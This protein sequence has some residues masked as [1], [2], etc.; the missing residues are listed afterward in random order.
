MPIADIHLCAPVYSPDADDLEAALDVNTPF[1]EG[2]FEETLRIGLTLDVHERVGMLDVIKPQRGEG[3][4]CSPKGETL[5]RTPVGEEPL[6]HAAVGQQ[7]EGARVDAERFGVGGPHECF[8]D[9]AR[10]MPMFGQEECC[11]Q[12]GG[13]G[14]NDENVCRGGIHALL[15]ALANNKSRDPASYSGAMPAAIDQ[16]RILDSVLTVWREHGYQGSS[17]RRIAALA[18]I[19]EMTLFRRYGD[20]AA[21]FRAALEFEAGQFR[22]DAIHYTGSLEI[23]LERIVG[24]YESL[25]ERS[26]PIILD[27]LLEAP[28]NPELAQIRPVPLEAIAH[29][30]AVME[31]YQQEGRLRQ[32]PPVNAVLVLLSPLLTA[33]LLRQAQP[34]LGLTLDRHQCVQ[35]FLQGWELEHTITHS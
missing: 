31:R 15:L 32:H 8:F 33:A 18:G 10:T 13:T 5:Q 11:G 9:D 2:L 22:A 16:T 27:F 17:T 12:S 24:A 19:S 4:S 35:S 34:Q 14:P 30:A 26:G 1:E 7:F 3:V 6:G 20:K 23:D 29:I 21:L 25:L 28:R